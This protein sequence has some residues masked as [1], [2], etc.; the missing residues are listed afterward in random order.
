M[1]RQ[2]GYICCVENA[3]LYCTFS[4]KEMV[5]ENEIRET[6]QKMKTSNKGRSEDIQKICMYYHT[7]PF[8]VL[9]L[10]S[11]AQSHDTL[12]EDIF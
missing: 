3:T 9:F 7:N 5:S 2:P 8:E 4:G 10:P 1:K 12:G 6:S 11:L